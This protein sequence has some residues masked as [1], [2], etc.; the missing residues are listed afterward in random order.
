[1]RICTKNTDVNHH[2]SSLDGYDEISL[3]G[4]SKQYKKKTKKG[5]EPED[6]GVNRT[7]PKKEIEGGTTI[8]ESAEMFTTIIAEKEPK[9]KKQ[10]GLC[11]CCNGIATVTNC[12][13]L[14]GSN[15]VKESF[16]I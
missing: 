3:T 4:A 6:F 14:E 12:S 5:Y 11:Q 10:C 8:E 9:L 13:P 16:I 1:M 2:S 15:E 7:N